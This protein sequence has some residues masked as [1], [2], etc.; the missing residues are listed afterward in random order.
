MSDLPVVGQIS[1]FLSSPQSK[2]IP[3]RELVASVARMNE[4]TSGVFAFAVVPAC[5]YA[6]AGYWLSTAMLR[7]IGSF[8]KPLNGRSAT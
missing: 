7:D 6:H 8:I 1:H 3:L 5:R 2:N 4:A